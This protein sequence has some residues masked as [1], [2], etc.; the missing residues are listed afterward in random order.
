MTK[1]YYAY[2]QTRECFLSGELTALDAGLEPLRVLKILIE[3]LGPGVKTGLW[4]THFRNVPVART[5]SPF[6]LIYLDGASRVVHAI[7]LS[8]DGEFAP[9]YGQ[10]ASALVL[11]PQSIASSKTRTGD[12]LL[13]QAAEDTAEQSAAD[14]SHGPTSQGPG[15]QIDLEP[16][17]HLHEVPFHVAADDNTVSPLEQFLAKQS[18]I[19]VD[20]G[21]VQPNAKSLLEL[22]PAA[23]PQ[24]S[25]I[26]PPTRAGG[27]ETQKTGRPW[28]R[29]IPSAVPRTGD[30]EPSRTPRIAPSSGSLAEAAP[31]AERV[32]APRQSIPA[33]S[34]PARDMPSSRAKV[35]PFPIRG[36]S[37]RVLPRTTEP[38][39]DSSRTEEE[40]EPLGPEKISL[41][42]R[43]LRL[44]FLRRERASRRDAAIPRPRKIKLPESDSKAVPR[45]VMRILRWLY[46]EFEISAEPQP[47]NQ[48][49]YS[50]RTQFRPEV[51]P[52]FDMQFWRWL[53]PEIRFQHPFQESAPRD[54][55]RS[56][57]LKKPGLVAYYFTG[58]PPRAH[59]LGDISVTGFYMHTEERWMPGTII[60]MT[61]QLID[62][63]GE[64]PTDTI[65]VH[66]RVVRW[67]PDGEGFEFVLAGFL[68]EPLPISY[69]KS[70]G[71]RQ[72]ADFLK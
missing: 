42:M 43:I 19:A 39:S 22:S 5:L 11:P 64:D 38:P 55:R 66:S 72:R 28:I 9:F 68:D 52:T 54:R 10:P 40:I 7:E 26:T 13:V 21:R 15:S 35:E 14:S 27:A 53:Y 33:Q 36:G 24:I 6:D 17:A 29:V 70:S 67:G 60:R 8:T 47:A 20:Q 48:Q 69:S 62:T 57:R 30:S 59:G 1:K 34:I 58:G 4:L 61:L 23:H 25:E 3:G 32:A 63:K 37:Q 41:L 44:R 2:N 12:Q 49:S 51:K 18:S 71:S 65:T 50:S 56:G 45:R 31:S 16:P 46:P